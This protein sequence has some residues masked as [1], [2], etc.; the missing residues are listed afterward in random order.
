V[1]DV[2]QRVLTYGDVTKGNGF[3]EALPGS[4]LGAELD[5]EKVR[6]YTVA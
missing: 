1:D 5:A 4:G 3:V 2:T 6:K